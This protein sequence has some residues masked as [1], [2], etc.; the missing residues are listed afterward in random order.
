M[1]IAIAQ[2]KSLA[3]KIAENISTHLQLINRAIQLD[4]NLIVFPELSLTAYEP[5]LAES[6]ATEVN[7]KTFNI[8][9]EKADEYSISIGVG[10]PTKTPNGIN[11]SM[12][13]FQPL[14]ERLV[15]SKRILHADEFPYFVA[16][17]HQPMLNI[18]GMNIALGICYETLQREHFVDAQQKGA[19]IYVASVA[20]PDRGTDKAYL[21]FPSIAKEF[22]TPIL[23]SNCVGFCD[24]FLSNGQSAVW[25]K[26]GNLINSLDNE[27]EGILLYDTTLEEVETWQ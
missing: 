1:K 27:N 12:L 24:N 11:I 13:I 6:L 19:D 23:M 16:G 21:H 9:Q 4:A 8:F 5:E 20:K 25:N 15:Y 18:Q 3:G 14:Q 10:M 7:S 26:E 17:E 2:S 22:Q